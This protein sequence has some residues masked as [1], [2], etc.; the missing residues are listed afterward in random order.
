[1]TQSKSARALR[2]WATAFAGLVNITIVLLLIALAW[3]KW[4][5]PFRPLSAADDI[6]PLTQMKLRSFAT[7]PTACRAFLT[8]A[9]VKFREVPDRTDQGF[10]TVTD[11]IAMTSGGPPLYPAGPVM[12]CPVAAGLVLWERHGLKE[13]ASDYMGSSVTRV[14]HLGTYSCRRQY[15]RETGSVSEHALAKAIDISGFSFKNGQKVSV[16]RGWATLDEP[17]SPAS[18]FLRAA[19]RQG[20][21]L[22]SVVL[23]PQANAAHRDHFHFDMGSMSSCR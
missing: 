7:N 2:G 19:H 14:E 3:P 9:G 1:M 17:Q 21:G 8:D 6:G 10:C 16:L 18:D 5:N 4:L 22:F 15:G 20:C 11:A 23:G 13:A 12:T